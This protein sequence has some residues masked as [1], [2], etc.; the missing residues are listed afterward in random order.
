MSSAAEIIRHVVII[1]M[2]PKS[3]IRADL[4]SAYAEEEAL[5]TLVPAGFTAERELAIGDVE[6][7]SPEVRVAFL[8]GAA[9]ILGPGLREGT[10]C[11]CNMRAAVMLPVAA[12]ASLLRDDIVLA[13][14]AWPA[15]AKIPRLCAERLPFGRDEKLEQITFEDFVIKL[16]AEEYR[17]LVGDFPAMAKVAAAKMEAAFDLS[18]RRREAP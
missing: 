2:L 8:K 14:K 9:L 1:G 5:T 13:R 16:A 15:F 10:H 17:E 7:L 3:A 11:I 18:S 4:I 12:Y 6:S